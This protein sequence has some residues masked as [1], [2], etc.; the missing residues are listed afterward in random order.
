MICSCI[1]LPDQQC[2]L[3]SIFITYMIDKFGDFFFLVSYLRLYN[4]ML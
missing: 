1:F 2:Q 3:V 4:Q